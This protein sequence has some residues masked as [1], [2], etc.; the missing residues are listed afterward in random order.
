MARPFADA[1]A[2][3]IGS[4]STVYSGATATFKSMADVLQEVYTD[5]DLITPASTA[6]VLTAN[7][8]GRWP[9]AFL[10]PSKDYKVLLKTSAGASIVT[11]SPFQRADGFLTSTSLSPYCLKAGFT[12]TG[13]M[14]GAE[15]A[16]VASASAID[17]DAATGNMLHVT[18]TTTIATIVLADG[19][20]RIVVFDGALTLTNS[21]N[22]ILG[23]ADIT[24]AAGMVLRFIGE[25]SGV[26]RCIGGYTATGKA[27]FEA[28][29]ILI[30]VGDE[31]TA[32]TVGNSK[33]T[34]RMPFAMILDQLPRA[35]LTTASTVNMPTVDIREAGTTILSTLL[36]IDANETTSVTAATPAVL[37]DTSL[38]DD[39]QMRIDIT[40]AG[41]NAAGLKVLLRGYRRSV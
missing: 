21:S 25:G 29:E 15:G 19:A 6:G 11:L 40:V 38:A 3:L 2:S 22:L 41:T 33:I 7:S 8:S 35:S 14:N 26:T 24:T 36:T 28:A 10:D 16:S 31:T 20:E 23:G 17:L 9:L 37:S 39:A 13:P 30:A 27:V 5:T 18:G 1:L 12:M 34:W 32:I 4:T